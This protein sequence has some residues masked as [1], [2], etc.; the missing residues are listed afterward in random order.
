MSDI[1]VK[2]VFVL[3]LDTVRRRL[4]RFG[5]TDVCVGRK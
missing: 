5:E 4:V 2:R 1:N 3:E